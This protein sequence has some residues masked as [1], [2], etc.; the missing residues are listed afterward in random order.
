MKHVLR[1]KYEFDFNLIGVCCH[2]KDYRLC[3]AIN[4][5]LDLNLSRLKEDIS[6][7]FNKKSKSNANFHIFSYECKI[8]LAQYYLISNKCE[9]TSLVPEK[10]HFDFFFMIKSN[11]IKSYNY[12]LQKL[13]SIPFILKSNKVNVEDLKSRENLIF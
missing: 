11:E 10:S 3:W 4:S 9:N 7:I 6:L 2:E 1:E 8:N 13:Q 5:I 12:Y